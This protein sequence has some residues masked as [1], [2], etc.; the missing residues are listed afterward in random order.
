MVGGRLVLTDVGGFGDEG[1]ESESGEGDL[2]P[3]GA[4]CMVRET[5]TH[6]V[7]STETTGA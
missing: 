2:G 5:G 7:T 1:L 3:D 6:T 4:S